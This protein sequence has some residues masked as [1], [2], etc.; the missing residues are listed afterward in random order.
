MSG[1]QNIRIEEGW[2]HALS[3][4]FDSKKFDQLRDFIKE[5]YDHYQVFPP[6]NEIFHAFDAC[7]FDK[8]KVVIIGQDPY[9]GQGQANG[10]CFSVA[11]GVKFPPSLRNI[12]KELNDDLQLPLPE[13][14]DL[15]RWAKQGVL[16][17]NATL[18]VRESSPNSHAGKGWELLTDLAIQ[19]VNDEKEG[20]VF[21]LWGA[22]AQKKASFIDEKKHL[23]LKSAHPSPFSA[24]RGFLGNRHF[25][26]TNEYLIENGSSPI[27]W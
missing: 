26:K 13:N 5:E 22:F 10:L 20:L 25:S 1:K 8:T 14:G 7:P 17:I 2:K 21:M 4:F 27:A 9:H 6:K 3:E 24:N 23:V 12:F 11:D 19:K 15:T 18:T 16:L